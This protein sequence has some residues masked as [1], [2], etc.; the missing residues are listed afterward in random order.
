MH[1]VLCLQQSVALLGRWPGQRM[2]DGW[3]PDLELN[4]ICQN[5]LTQ[6]NSHITLFI[7]WQCMS[8][9]IPNQISNS[10]KGRINEWTIDNSIWELLELQTKPGIW[11]ERLL[12][13]KLLFKVQARFDERWSGRLESPQWNPLSRHGDTARR[14]NVRTWR[15]ASSW[16]EGVYPTHI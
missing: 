14:Q 4:G 2:A 13:V 3:S 12:A 1:V 8:L 16:R 5:V 9:Q 7:Y 15:C 6:Q 11:R 10:T